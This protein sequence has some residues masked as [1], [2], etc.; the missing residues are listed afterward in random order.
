MEMIING[1]LSMIYSGLRW[2]AE[3]AVKNTGESIK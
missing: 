2:V 1:H 3:A